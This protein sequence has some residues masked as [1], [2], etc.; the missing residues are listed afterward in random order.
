MLRPSEKKG[1]RWFRNTWANARP[2]KFASQS[3]VCGLARSS[4]VRVSGGA[5]EKGGGKIIALALDATNKR[6]GRMK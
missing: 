6:Q 5:V 2:R 4:I 3:T 1:L